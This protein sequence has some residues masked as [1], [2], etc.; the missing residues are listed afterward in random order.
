MNR[1]L[2]RYADAKTTLCNSQ[3]AVPHGLGLS[4][5][6]QETE[7]KGHRETNLLPLPQAK[8]P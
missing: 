7:A 5:D 2:V 6:V 4:V 1:T 8:T 3:S